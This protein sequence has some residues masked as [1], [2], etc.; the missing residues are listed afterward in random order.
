M[1]W[2]FERKRHTCFS[3]CNGVWVGDLSSNEN[4]EKVN[5]NEIWNGQSRWV[6][7]MRDRNFRERETEEEK[8]GETHTLWGCIELKVGVKWEQKRAWN[9][10]KGCG[11]D[12]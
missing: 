10:E 2:A 8:G 1:I 4:S 5:G 11:G 9:H 6:E 12:P 3:Q 7:P